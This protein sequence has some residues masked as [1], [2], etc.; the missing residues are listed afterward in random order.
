MK[1]IL[2]SACLVALF[3]IPA[4]AVF[5]CLDGLPVNARNFTVQQG[6]VMQFSQTI[7]DIGCGGV[8]LKTMADTRSATTPYNVA[9]T[10]GMPW[11]DVNPKSGSVTMQDSTITLTVDTTTLSPGTF[12]GQITF[13]G[14]FTPVSLTINLTVTDPVFCSVGLSP[15]AINVTVGPTEMQEIGFEILCV[16]PNATGELNWTATVK[17][18]NESA[19]DWFNI[20]PAKGTDLTGSFCTS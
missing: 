9:V 15:E 11:V 2:A 8:P 19:G 16:P 12:V 6:L 10:Q 18:L 7:N 17:L 5:T 1:R 13:T 20:S 14:S 3:S 4:K